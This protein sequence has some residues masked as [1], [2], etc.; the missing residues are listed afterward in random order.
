M[1]MPSTNASEDNLVPV[2]VSA[3]QFLEWMEMEPN[4]TSS[5][6]V[7]LS[8]GF[9][10][11]V[12]SWRVLF[13]STI[14]GRVLIC[15][16][17]WILGC[18]VYAI[19][20]APPET[21]LDSPAHVYQQIQEQIRNIPLPIGSPHYS[22]YRKHYLEQ[23]QQFLKA[24]ANEP[25]TVAEEEGSEQQRGRLP[26][27][28]ATVML[29]GLGFG[30]WL[31]VVVLAGCE[32]RYC[33]MSI[34]IEILGEK[35]L[36][37]C[38][39]VRLIRL[40]RIW[41]SAPQ[42]SEA[43]LLEESKAGTDTKGKSTNVAATTPARGAV[44]SS[45][46]NTGN[47]NAQGSDVASPAGGGSTLGAGQRR[48][49]KKKKISKDPL[50]ASAPDRANQG[51]QHKMAD[52]DVEEEEHEKDKEESGSVPSPPIKHE[53][54]PSPKQKG[55]TGSGAIVQ[56]GTAKP[57]KE[58]PKRP[59]KRPSATDLTL[60][61][62]SALSESA[63]EPQPVS[64]AGGQSSLGQC[65]ADVPVVVNALQ[66][67]ETQDMP[68]KV[69]A[70]K[71]TDLNDAAAPVAAPTPSGT[72]AWDPIHCFCDGGSRTEG[73][74]ETTETADT[75]NE[76]SQVDLE[77]APISDFVYGSAGN[78]AGGLLPFLAARRGDVSAQRLGKRSSRLLSDEAVHEVPTL[79]P[80]L[81]NCSYSSAQMD[82]PT[83]A[84][85]SS[86]TGSEQ[87][88]SEED[89]TGSNM[90]W[91]LATLTTDDLI[92]LLFDDSIRAALIRRG[93]P[94]RKHLLKCL[95]MVQISPPQVVDHLN[96]GVEGTAPGNWT[97][98]VSSG[99]LRADAPAFI[100][101][102]ADFCAMDVPL[103]CLPPEQLLLIRAHLEYLATQECSIASEISAQ[104]SPEANWEFLC[105]AHAE[106]ARR[107]EAAARAQWHARQ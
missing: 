105:R 71:A 12:A 52:K 2:G 101:A 56:D 7:Q 75:S 97:E 20:I 69:A 74:Q 94:I 93:I 53:V 3:I 103:A 100:P 11:G 88:V 26:F 70:D 58:E 80:G 87:W 106:A 67:R 48:H 9:E 23:Y 104:G 31:L 81:E 8:P 28:N 66:S 19:C 89:Q 42:V 38:K 92:R 44:A 45:R 10:D 43:K 27:L 76:S 22:Y 18:L 15:A 17:A 95:S 77:D 40:P 30:G 33:T 50:A 35:W 102:N 68:A 59:R 21:A 64:S 24:R 98:G 5:P 4:G 37:L 86:D 62:S 82:A 46:G 47:S 90:L 49:H 65:P 107:A 39:I 51:I 60:R 13:F 14:G 34:W 83:P 61:G 54:E 16:T 63:P 41:Q 99:I 55:R 36:A 85:G 79:P 84:A 29:R 96:E 32:Y 1:E 78:A 72:K 91:D 57:V 25:T 73:S 6:K